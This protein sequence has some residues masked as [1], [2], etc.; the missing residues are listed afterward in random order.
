MKNTNNNFLFPELIDSQGDNN[1]FTYL[2]NSKE[3][4]RY[5]EVLISLYPISDPRLLSSISKVKDSIDNL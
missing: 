4:E 2:L 1:T 3:L 5:Y